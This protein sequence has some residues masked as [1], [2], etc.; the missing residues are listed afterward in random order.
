MGLL[1]KMKIILPKKKIKKVKMTFTER[2]LFMQQVKNVKRMTIKK[3]ISNGK[4]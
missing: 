4:M 2:L 3:Q 1:D